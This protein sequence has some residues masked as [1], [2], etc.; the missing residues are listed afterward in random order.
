M[1]KKTQYKIVKTLDIDAAKNLARKQGQV[2]PND[3]VV[4]LGLHKT[5]Y[6]RPDMPKELRHASGEWLRSGGYGR[7]TGEPL[8]PE[9]ELPYT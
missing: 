5:R 2:P 6:E 3:E 4:L 8:L 1:K 9:G 7:L